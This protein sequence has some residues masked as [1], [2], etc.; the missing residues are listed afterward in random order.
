VADERRHRALADAIAPPAP[1]RRAIRIVDDEFA[2]VRDA[3]D[4]HVVAAGVRLRRRQIARPPE[5]VSPAAELFT[6]IVPPPL[7]SVGEPD[8]APVKH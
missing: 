7:A 4:G 8:E 3:D 5:R 6:P 2:V 1:R